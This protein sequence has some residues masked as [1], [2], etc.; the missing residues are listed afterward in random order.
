MECVE[1]GIQEVARRES[2]FRTYGSSNFRFFEHTRE[3]ENKFPVKSFEKNK[4][5]VLLALIAVAGIF[6]L[7]YFV[8]LCDLWVIE[9]LNRG[10]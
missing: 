5:L 4:A 6:I 2:N 7:S 9:S 10:L 1:H 3:L 8:I